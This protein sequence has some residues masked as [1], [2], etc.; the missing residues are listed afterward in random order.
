[1]TAPDTNPPLDDAAAVRT[2]AGEWLVAKSAAKTWSSEDQAALDAWLQESPAHLL[3]YWRLEAAWANASRLT[4]L[5]QPMR[6]ESK[7]GRA[8]RHNW[9]AFAA[10]AIAAIIIGAGGYAFYIRAPAVKS[11]STA[12][13]GHETLKLTDGSTIELTTDTAIRV[14]VGQVRHVW[15]DRG[16]A[17]FQVVHD[18]ARPFVL[19]IGDQ[20]VVDLG[21]EFSARRAGDLVKVAVVKG[22]VLVESTASDIKYVPVT[23][24]A[25]QMATATPRSITR[26]T[27]SPKVIAQALSWRRDLLVFD[28]TPLAEVAERFN[29]YNS[30]KLVIAD[31]SIAKLKVGGAFPTGG[32]ESFARVAQHILK[33]H[34]EDDGNRAVLTR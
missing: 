24:T 2:R 25:G 6:G 14:A 22:S 4:A 11:Y 16:E 13:G 15:L 26:E 27:P 28:D 32:V 9:L 20:R 33:L 29:R 18:P 17:F 1:M 21:T 8:F 5:R 34:V 7:G 10:A 31:E 30:K 3:A 23:L 12:L 19:Q